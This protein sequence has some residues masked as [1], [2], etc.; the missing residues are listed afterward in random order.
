MFYLMLATEITEHT[1]K[2]NKR[3]CS[4]TSVAKTIT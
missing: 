2:E 4:V 1:E 3:F